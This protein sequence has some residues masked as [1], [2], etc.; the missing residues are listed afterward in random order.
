MKSFRQLE[1]EMFYELCALPLLQKELRI[2]K[3]LKEM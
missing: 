3:E 2:G 1:A